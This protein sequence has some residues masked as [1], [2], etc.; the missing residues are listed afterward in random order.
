MDILNSRNS[1]ISFILRWDV[2]RGGD[3]MCHVGEEVGG[4]FPSINSELCAQP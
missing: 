1:D 4:F 3:G 2:P